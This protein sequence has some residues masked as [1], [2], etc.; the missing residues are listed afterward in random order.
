[1]LKFE[2][3]LH[4]VEGGRGYRSMSFLGKNMKRGMINKEKI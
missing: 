3:T 4:S 1:M 2:N